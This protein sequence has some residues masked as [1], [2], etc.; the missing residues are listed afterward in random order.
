M[1]VLILNR[2]RR[3]DQINAKN[4]NIY[5]LSPWTLWILGLELIACTGT[6]ETF[7][8]PNRE[9]HGYI[10]T[11]YAASAWD[12]CLASVSFLNLDNSFMFF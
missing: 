11:S 6:H 10:T 12:V 3:E 7:L 2:K 5:Q 4:L 8:E 9:I 1:Y